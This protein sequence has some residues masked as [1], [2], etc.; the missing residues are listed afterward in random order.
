MRFHKEARLH[1]T[2]V[3]KIALAS[4]PREQRTHTTTKEKQVAQRVSITLVDDLDGTEAVE[5]VTFGLDGATYEI[6]LSEQNAKEL[7][8][9]L[10]DFIP[11]ARKVSGKKRRRTTAGGSESKTIREWARGQGMEVSA[12]GVVPVEIVKAYEAA[13]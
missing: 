5:T 8:S 13:H 2:V 3:Q 10:D 9:R 12:R 6:D 11:S 1:E 4:L 7:R